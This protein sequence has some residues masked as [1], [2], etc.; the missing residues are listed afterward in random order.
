[1]QNTNK[2]TKIIITTL[3][4]ITILFLFLFL[5][6]LVKLRNMET[7]VASQQV[8]EKILD[9]TKL[10]FDKVLQGTKEVSFDD[11]LKLENSVRELNDKEIFDSWVKFTKAKDQNEVQIDFYNLFQ[12]LLNKIKL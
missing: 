2:I 6:S 4:I 12:L 5:S 9:F 1:M 11:R 7:I 8:N 10:F 3:S